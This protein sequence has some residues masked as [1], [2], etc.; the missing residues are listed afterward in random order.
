[1]GGIV[2]RVRDALTV[3][4]VYAAGT[5]NKGGGI[6]GGGQNGSTPAST[7][8]NCV[9]WNN[10][11]EFGT[12]AAGDVVSGSLFYDGTN[13]AALQQA[14]VAWGAPW[15]CDM[16]EGSYP[17]FNKDQLTGIQQIAERPRADIYMLDGRLVKANAA[18]VKSLPRGIYIINGK[19]VMVR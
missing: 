11:T 2:G 15:T 1:M 13:F 18:D 9:V 19:K 8:T 16:A 17:T 10:A 6:V 7:Y 3:E 14:V 5:M 4:N 12:T